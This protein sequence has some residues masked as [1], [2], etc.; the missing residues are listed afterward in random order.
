MLYG[1]QKTR[2]EDLWTVGY[3][4]PQSYSDGVMYEWFGLED[5]GNRKAAFAFINYLNG[6]EGNLFVEPNVR[7]SATSRVLRDISKE[8]C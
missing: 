5:F 2:G 6:G 8:D 4:A 1:V 3:W 7:P